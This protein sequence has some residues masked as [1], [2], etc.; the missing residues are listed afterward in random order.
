MC[1]CMPLAPVHR[2][3]AD[4]AVKANKTPRVMKMVNAGVDAAN[5]FE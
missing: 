1:A 3:F 5:A 2:L 4:E